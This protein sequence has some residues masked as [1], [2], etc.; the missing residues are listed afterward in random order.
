MEGFAFHDAR[1]ALIST[2][3][4]RLGRKPRRVGHNLLL[5]QSTRKQD[6]LRFLFEPTVP[7]TKNMAERDGRRISAS[8]ARLSRQRESKLGI[9][10]GRW[11][12]NQAN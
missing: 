2:A 7:F 4:K 1:P 8:S 3:R 12:A 9:S 6:V 10:C 5:R 11:P